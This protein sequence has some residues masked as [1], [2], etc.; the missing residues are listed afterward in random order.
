MAK[1]AQLVGEV[2]NSQFNQVFYDVLKPTFRYH[3]RTYFIDT[4]V[5]ILF[6]ILSQSFLATAER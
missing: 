5:A 6:A 1:K 3:S 4:N 2:R